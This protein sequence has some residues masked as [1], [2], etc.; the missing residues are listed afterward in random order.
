MWL[1][2]VASVLK[3]GVTVAKLLE[4]GHSVVV[5]CSDGWD[6]TPQICAL[7]E[8]L[9]DPY[10]R[11]LQGFALLIE[12][13]WLSFGHMFDTR[14]GHTR[15][16]RDEPNESPIFLLFLDCVW[17]ILQQFPCAAEFNEKLL[18]FLAEQSYSCR[19]GTFLRNTAQQRKADRLTELTPSIWTVVY[20]QRDK[21]RNGFYRS[22]SHPLSPSSS[23]TAMRFWESYYLRFIYPPAHRDSP[24]KVIAELRRENEELRR[25]L[26]V[27][28]SS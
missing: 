4:K 25:A 28:T 2:L 26:M 14:Q 21:Y 19:F 8:F 16:K 1:Q 5:H 7:A 10:Y 13:E 23:L 6:R 3:G 9:L 20:A 24:Q 22:T 18:F 12:K 27:A 17:Q 15:A 11:T